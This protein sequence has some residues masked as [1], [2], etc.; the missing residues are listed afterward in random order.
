MF[1]AT[2]YTQSYFRTMYTL[3]VSHL[4]T[5][6]DRLFEHVTIGKC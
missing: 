6:N 3:R 4:H 1:Y 2:H 5:I